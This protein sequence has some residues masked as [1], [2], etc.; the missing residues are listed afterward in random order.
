MTFGFTVDS[1][2]V[3][4]SALRVTFFIYKFSCKNGIVHV[5]HGGRIYTQ[6]HIGQAFTKDSIEEFKASFATLGDIRENCI[7]LIT[8]SQNRMM[9]RREMYQ[10]LDACKKYDVNMGEK[11]KEKVID[12][13]SAK[14]GHTRWGL[15]NGITEVAQNHIL[16]NRVAYETWADRILSVKSA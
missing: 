13:V 9:S 1:S 10:I 14:Y 16:E 12:L 15:I 4:K 8:A 11:E 6:K 7:G 5:S 3:G 2:D